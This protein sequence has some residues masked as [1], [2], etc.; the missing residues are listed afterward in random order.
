MKFKTVAVCL[1]RRLGN[2][3]KKFK[4]QIKYINK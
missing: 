3:V 4:K 2:I 1:Q